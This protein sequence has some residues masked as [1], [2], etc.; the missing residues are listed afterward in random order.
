[1]PMGCQYGQSSIH[2]MHHTCCEALKVFVDVDIDSSA[3]V[4]CA[5]LV[6]DWM[7]KCQSPRVWSE[8]PIRTLHA[9]SFYSAFD[10]I[11]LKIFTREFY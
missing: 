6:L 2:T 5:L 7:G 8:R 1:M 11:K 3:W 4:F 9:F 10:F